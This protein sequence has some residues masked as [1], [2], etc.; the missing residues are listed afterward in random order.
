MP[1][2][3]IK[4]SIHGRVQGVGYRA[5]ATAMA[6]RLGVNG[7]VRNNRRAATVE[8]LLSADDALVDAMIKQCEKGPAT[9]RVLEVKVETTMETVEA[10]FRQLPSV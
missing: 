10:G 5:W 9:A 1:I 3:T 4:V 6:E 7:W 8:M 2:K